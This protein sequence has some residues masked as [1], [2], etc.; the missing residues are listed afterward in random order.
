MT[1]TY[2]DYPIN[3]RLYEILGTSVF[4]AR[5]SFTLIQYCIEVLFLRI[6]S[7][8]MINGRAGMRMGEEKVKNT[9]K[10][11]DLNL[12]CKKYSTD[13]FVSY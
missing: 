6:F 10:K 9:S 1:R 13:C 8:S 3:P 11:H 2:V 12:S 7:W 5:Y 4:R